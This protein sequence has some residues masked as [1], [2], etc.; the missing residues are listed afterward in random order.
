[1]PACRRSALLGLVAE[2]GMSTGR[3][4][5]ATRE[6]VILMRSGGISGGHMMNA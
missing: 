4:R 3:A 1:M 6:A 5:D 2:P